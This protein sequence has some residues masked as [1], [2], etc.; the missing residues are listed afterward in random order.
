M[1]KSANRLKST[2]LTFEIFIFRLLVGF[3]F[4]SHNAR[5]MADEIVALIRS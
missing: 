1:V 3:E 4:V 2:T 5:M